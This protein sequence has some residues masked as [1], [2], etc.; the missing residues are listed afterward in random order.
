MRLLAGILVLVVAG[1]PA[2]AEDRTWQGVFVGATSFTMLGAALAWY[3]MNQVD[4]A[5]KRLC[6]G[7]YANDCGHP[8]PNT[9]A[10]IDHLN[11]NGER[12]STL[13]WVGTGMVVAGGALAAVAAYKGFA[14]GTK[15]ESRTAL[16]PVLTRDGAGATL[17]IR[18]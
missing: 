1:A 3:G 9:Q 17:L 14:G 4:H 5:E 12:G 16:A 2:H 6:T 11:Q 10:E 8:P 18:W 7:N 13:A 15:Q